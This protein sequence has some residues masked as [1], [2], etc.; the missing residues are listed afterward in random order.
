LA[1]P[2][3]S[4]ASGQ[5]AVQSARAESARRSASSAAEMAAADAVAVERMQE[6]SVSAG[7]SRRVVAGRVFAL[8]D[9]VW[10]DLATRTDARTL[11]IRPFSAAYFELIRLLPELE[12]ILREL[13]SVSVGGGRLTLAFVADGGERLTGDR[14]AL[15][16]DFRAAR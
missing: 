14:A 3:P 8:R 12:P 13:E 15:V 7:E 10:T 1:P 16:G 6:E 2:P 11:R 4:A 5:G 9:G